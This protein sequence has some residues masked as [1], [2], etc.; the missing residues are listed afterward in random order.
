MNQYVN[1]F[2]D[3]DTEPT[4]PPSAGKPRRA[5]AAPRPEPAF[6][7]GAVRYEKMDVVWVGE[8]G[9]PVTLTLTARAAQALLLKPTCNGHPAE[10][11]PATAKAPHVRGSATSEAAARKMDR[12]LAG[13]REAV[14][15]VFMVAGAVVPGLTDNDVL[16][17]LTGRGWS[18]NTPRARR[19]E[20]VTDSWLEDSGERRNGSIVWRPTPKAWEWWKTQNASEN[21]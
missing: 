1:L 19:V 5:P 6:V 9:Q 14:L 3:T 10:T 18:A 15:R 4:W 11:S 21:P 12:K 2:G 17:T 20:L 7:V 8:D 13:K 16:R